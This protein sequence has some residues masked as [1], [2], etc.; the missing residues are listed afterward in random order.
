MFERP[1]VVSPRTGRISPDASESFGRSLREVLAGNDELPEALLIDIGQY[2]DGVSGAFF[3]QT[4]QRQR[5]SPRLSLNLEPAQFLRAGLAGTS[6]PRQLPIYLVRAPDSVRT[7]AFAVHETTDLSGIEDN[8]LGFLLPGE[9]FLTPQLILKGDVVDKWLAF[10]AP[11]RPAPAGRGRAVPPAPSHLENR[12]AEEPDAD[13]LAIVEMDLASQAGSSL[14]EHI[15]AFQDRRNVQYSRATAADVGSVPAGL[16]ETCQSILHALEGHSGLPRLDRL[17]YFFAGS[18]TLAAPDTEAADSQAVRGFLTPPTLT[19]MGS[20]LEPVIFSH[21]CASVVFALHRARARIRTGAVDAVLLAG[22]LQLSPETVQSMSSLGT[23]SNCQAR[24]FDDQRDGTHISAG[25]GALLVMH[26]NT[27]RRLGHKISGV[28]RSLH[29]DVEDFGAATDSDQVAR[30]LSSTLNTGLC[31]PDAV[32][33]HATGTLQGDDS[34]ARALATL[35]DPGTPVVASKGA[36]GH[37]LHAAGFTG[38]GHALALLGQ[39][40]ICGTIGLTNPLQQ[41]LWMPVEGEKES[42]SGPIHRVLVTSVGFGGN[43]G[44]LVLESL[45]PVELH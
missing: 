27:A 8:L 22:G 14:E 42:L 17:E 2:T 26:P 35:L 10:R 13:G 45:I 24:P 18:G 37:L 15:A 5:V 7:R 20:S 38:I 3:D 43:L 36:T 21:A 12:G 32:V 25:Y 29:I 6:L 40:T 33:A 28:I 44:S 9:V 34:E 39:S 31:A 30:H 4:S 23:L 11:G 1:P 41:P 16:Q 19:Y